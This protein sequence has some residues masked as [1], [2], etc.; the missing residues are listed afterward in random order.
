MSAFSLIGLVAVAIVTCYYVV[1]KAA[2]PCDEPEHGDNT[3]RALGFA[4][5]L[6]VLV[7]MLSLT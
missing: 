6:F 2:D 5:L 3:L 7:L 4:A 1:L